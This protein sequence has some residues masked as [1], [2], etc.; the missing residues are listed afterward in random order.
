[1]YSLTRKLPLKSLAASQLPA[2]GISM[3]IAEL[4]YKWHSFTLECLGFLATWYAVDRILV[5][6]GDR[7][8]RPLGR[9]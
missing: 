5:A 7:R 9:E 4:F 1:M 8:P 3:L 6:I 2:V